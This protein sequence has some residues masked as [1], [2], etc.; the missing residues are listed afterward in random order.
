MNIEKYVLIQSCKGVAT[1][2]P[3]IAKVLVECSPHNKHIWQ[4]LDVLCSLRYFLSLEFGPSENYAKI[5]QT[6]G[7]NGQ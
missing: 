3:K 1:E 6:K 2:F 7:H 4:D 5:K